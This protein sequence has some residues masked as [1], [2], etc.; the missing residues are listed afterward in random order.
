MAGYHLR[1]IK[2]AQYGTLEKIYE[3]VEE[4]R[5]SQ[6]QGSELMVLIE[7]SDLIGAVSGYLE[8]AH[9]TLQLEDLILMSEITGRAFKNGGR[10]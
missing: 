5:D 8:C 9:P 6:E 4:I 10:S 3:E 7:L 1:D 2:K